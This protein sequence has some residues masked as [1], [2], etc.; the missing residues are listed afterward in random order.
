M[1]N[2]E[3]KKPG[4][5]L[6]RRRAAEGLLVETL[7]D[8]TVIYDLESK[9]AHCLKEL[10][11]VAFAYADGINSSA[12]IAELAGYR[13]GR[14]VTEDE[15]GD[16]LAQLEEQC[17]SSAHRRAARRTCRDERRCAHSRPPAPARS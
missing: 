3:S 7:G 9:E 11:A 17:W 16:S 5:R 15:V 10:A 6:A 2:D 4:A 13:L 1:K 14:P 8:E 12:D